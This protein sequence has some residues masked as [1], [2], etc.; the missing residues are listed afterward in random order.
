MSM[1][2]GSSPTSDSSANLWS[3]SSRLAATRRTVI[4]N[5]SPSGSRIWKS[6]STLSISKGT[7]CSASQR[8]TPRA[9]RRVHTA[10]APAGLG[11]LHPVHGDLLDDHVTAADGGDD[12][13]GLD[14]GGGQQPLD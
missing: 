13:L 10:H 1:I 4:C 14:A 6:S 12:L 5:P 9:S 8:M 11:L 2:A 3:T 7:C